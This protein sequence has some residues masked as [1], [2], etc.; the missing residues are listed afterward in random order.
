MSH[1]DFFRYSISTLARAELLATKMKLGFGKDSL[2]GRDSCA[3]EDW[4][5]IEYTPGYGN[6]KLGGWFVFRPGVEK[7]GPHSKE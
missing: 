3:N 5:I 2:L 1:M 7:G 6:I 4:Q